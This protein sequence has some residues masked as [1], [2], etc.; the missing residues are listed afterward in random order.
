MLKL[1]LNSP[2]GIRKTLGGLELQYLG[3][4]QTL[5]GGAAKSFMLTNVTLL[6]EQVKKHFDLSFSVNNLF[7]IK[8]SNPGT[9]GHQQE[10]IPQD[11]RTFR[12]KLIYHLSN[13]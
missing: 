7:A 1:N 8:Y 11:G 6:S 10:L 12:L 4:R 2:L 3:E 13:K 9:A 5:A